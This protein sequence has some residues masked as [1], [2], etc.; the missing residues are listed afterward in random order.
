MGT[1]PQVDLV[2]LVEELL[3]TLSDN[4]STLNNKDGCFFCVMPASAQ[5]L[6]ASV[7][8]HHTA[9]WLGSC[10]PTLCHVG[11][12]SVHTADAMLLVPSSTITSTVGIHDVQFVDL[13]V[14]R[15]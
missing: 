15:S 5:L 1:C 3:W 4:S 7:K 10:G 8:S 14:I 2:G 12:E 6:K 11:I 9:A 13:C